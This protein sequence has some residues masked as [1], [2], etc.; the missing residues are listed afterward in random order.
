MQRVY[1]KNYRS[2]PLGYRGKESEPEVVDVTSSN[3][4]LFLDPIT[5]EPIQ[6]VPII[7]PKLLLDGKRWNIEEVRGKSKEDVIKMVG[8]FQC[9]S[10]PMVDMTEDSVR[11]L[12]LRDSYRKCRLFSD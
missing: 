11:G 5:R 4:T 8:E 6:P 3:V 9:Q 7:C 2:L 10:R 1:G 12:C